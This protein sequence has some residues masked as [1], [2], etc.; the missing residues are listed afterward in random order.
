MYA[1]IHSFRKHIEERS[2]A[3]KQSRNDIEAS[4]QHNLAKLQLH[5]EQQHS[6]ERRRKQDRLIHGKEYSD[7]MGSQHEKTTTLSETQQDIADKVNQGCI[8]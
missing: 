2:S 1:F 6:L 3:I 7:Q 8:D 5:I 4:E